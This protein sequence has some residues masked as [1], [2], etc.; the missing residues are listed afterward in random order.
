M[1][2]VGSILEGVEDLLYSVRPGSPTL[3]GGDLV[4]P[5]KDGKGPG[6][7]SVQGREEDHWEATTAKER[8]DLGIPTAGGGKEGSRDGGDTDIH[9]TEAEYGRTIYCDTADSGPM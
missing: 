6:E 3:W 7:F 9:H 4:P 5:S 1:L 2:P 8:R